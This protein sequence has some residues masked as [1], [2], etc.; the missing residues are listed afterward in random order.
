MGDL[1]RTSVLV[2]SQTWKATVTIKAHT[3]SE[4]P[5]AGV[6]VYVMW[7]NGAFGITNCVTN[8]NGVC[9]ITKT[10]LGLGIKSVT[11]TVTNATLASYTY[12][13]TA[14]H[15]PDGESNGTMIII[16]KP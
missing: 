10:N 15:D 3:A 8:A 2:T 16:P 9:T 4:Q 13:A 1:D 11:L 12:M 6:K 7:T 5:L 14:N